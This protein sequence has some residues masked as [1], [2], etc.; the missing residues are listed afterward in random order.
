MATL[1][2]SHVSLQFIYR[3]LPKIFITQKTKYVYPNLP[4]VSE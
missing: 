4:D 1:P 3:K 2:V